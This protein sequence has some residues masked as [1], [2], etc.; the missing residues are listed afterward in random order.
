M[1][2][3]CIC[4][5][6]EQLLEADWSRTGTEYQIVVKPCKAC[7]EA[8]REEAKE[9]DIGSKIELMKEKLIKA[10][11]NLDEETEEEK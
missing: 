11:E 2:L 10:V 9:E 3:S 8:E 1:F 5:K 6:C 7:L 4:E